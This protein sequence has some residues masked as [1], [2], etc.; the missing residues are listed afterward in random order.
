[1]NLA[2]EIPLSL[3]SQILGRKLLAVTIHL[4]FR[5]RPGVHSEGFQSSGHYQRLLRSKP[6]LLIFIFESRV[7]PQP[8]TLCLEHSL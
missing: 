8:R 2:G 3:W 7:C 6:I 1:M 5:F 4:F